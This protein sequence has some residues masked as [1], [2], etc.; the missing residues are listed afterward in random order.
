[1]EKVPFGKFGFINKSSSDWIREN[2]N[3]IIAVGVGVLAV[4]GWTFYQWN[5][6]SAAD[7]LVAEKLFNEWSGDKNENLVKLQKILKQHPELHA[8]YDG[9][10]AQKLLLSS[11]EGLAASFS[12]ATQNRIGE[13][14]PHYRQFSNCSILIGEKKFDE[15]LSQSIQL[16]QSL[17]QDDLF[18]K[19]NSEIVKHGA[20]LYGYNLLRIA[21]LEQMVGN[22]SGELSAWKNFKREAGWIES[23]PPTRGLDTESFKLITQNFQKNDVSL[24]DFIQYRETLLA[25]QLRP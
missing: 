16:K 7:Y 13:F 19:T 18:W 11:Q 5:T 9:R 23:E 21:F 4:A 8:K 1:M 20:V 15:A 24:K 6:G 10:I 17:D 3:S 14:S 12:R 2:I 22:I 25:N